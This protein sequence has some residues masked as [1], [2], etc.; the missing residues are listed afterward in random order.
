M[1]SVD[2]H[3]RSPYPL[4]YN[5]MIVKAAIFVGNLSGPQLSKLECLP[6]SDIEALT[7]V[8]L[9]Y[10]MPRERDGDL[11]IF[12]ITV[13]PSAP[14]YPGDAFV[15]EDFVEALFDALEIKTPW[16]L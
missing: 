2:I 3:E 1:L 11:L 7:H 16:S 14:G 9:D 10:G 15:K 8:H 13:D 12:N 4:I 6:R 5:P